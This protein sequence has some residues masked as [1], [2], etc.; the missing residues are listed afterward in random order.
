ME[1]YILGPDIITTTQSRKE[2]GINLGPLKKTDDRD[3]LQLSRYKK[4]KPSTIIYR[5]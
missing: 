2:Q 4:V 3:S 1:G 5:K